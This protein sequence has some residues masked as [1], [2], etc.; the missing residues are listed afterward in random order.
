[1]VSTQ[2]AIGRQRGAHQQRGRQQADGAQQARKQ[3]APKPVSDIGDV[4]VAERRQR[5]QN[6]DAERGDAQFELGIDAQRMAVAAG[7]TARAA[8]SRRTCHP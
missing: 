7:R 6:Q 3:I 1:M 2:R 5:E 8:G 4:E